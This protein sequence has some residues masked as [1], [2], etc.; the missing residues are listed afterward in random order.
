MEDEE[1]FVIILRMR[2]LE[3]GEFESPA[4]GHIAGE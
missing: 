1:G 3:L 4:W 2:K